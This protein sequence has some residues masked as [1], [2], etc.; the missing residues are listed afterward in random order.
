MPNQSFQAVRL[1]RALV[2]ALRAIATAWGAPDQARL[3]VQPMNAG[4]SFDL[5]LT[6]AT[7]DP[8]LTLALDTEEAIL[9]QV[10]LHIPAELPM[11]VV[12]ARNQPGLRRGHG[13]R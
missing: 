7:S 11:T 5:A 13:A 9:N 12:V 1:L 10:T 6:A 2:E 8:R 3:S 4:P